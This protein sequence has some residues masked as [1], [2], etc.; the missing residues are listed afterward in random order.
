MSTKKLTVMR[1]DEEI[2]SMADKSILIRASY[3]VNQRPE[4]FSAYVRRLIVDNYHYNKE[5]L[6]KRMV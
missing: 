6:E 1:I 5:M 2:R 3:R 4:T